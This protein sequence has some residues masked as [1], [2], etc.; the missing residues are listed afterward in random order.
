MKNKSRE[1]ER[2]SRPP[3]RCRRK[4]ANQQSLENHSE[5]D[6]ARLRGFDCRE[7]AGV[8]ADAVCGGV[9]QR[10]RNQSG[11]SDNAGASP[12]RCRRE[13]RT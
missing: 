2:Q 3:E 6:F 7:L 4:D 11:G 9:K 13:S 1:N 8:A 12:L 5:D 10:G